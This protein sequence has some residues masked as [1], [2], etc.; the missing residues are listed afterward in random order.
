MALYIIMTTVAVL[1]Q[2]VQ[3]TAEK[4]PT[5]NDKFPLI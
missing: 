5:A 1:R 2:A 4:A 3:R